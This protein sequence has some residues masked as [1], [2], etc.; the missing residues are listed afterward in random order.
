MAKMEGVE[1]KAQAWGDA[2][3]HV[4]PW[5]LKDSVRDST[6]LSWP[7]YKNGDTLL[8]RVSANDAECADDPGHGSRW[9]GTPTLV[10]L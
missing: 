2:A 10:W 6:L 5:R 4:H 8:I 7:A 9:S 3:D 1:A